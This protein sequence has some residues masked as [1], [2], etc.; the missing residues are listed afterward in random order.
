MLITKAALVYLAKAKQSTGHTTLPEDAHLQREH[1]IKGFFI[2]T[3]SF[4]QIGIAKI[5]CYHNKIVLSTKRLVAVTK[6]NI[7]CP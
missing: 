2:P 3:K 5:F 6:K 7:C 1:G 4:V